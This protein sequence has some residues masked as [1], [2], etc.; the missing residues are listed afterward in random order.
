MTVRGVAILAAF[1]QKPQ[2]KLFGKA[3]KCLF[4]WE[5]EPS[6]CRRARGD[7]PAGAASAAAHVSRHG[8]T[9]REIL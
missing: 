4:C 2:Q 7:A 6:E 9:K 3:P 1:M 5:R 8:V